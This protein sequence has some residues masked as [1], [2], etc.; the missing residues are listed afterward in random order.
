[1]AE[2]PPFV[3]HRDDVPEVE[4]RYPAPFNAEALSLGRDLGRTAGSRALGTWVERLLPGRRT[5]FTHAHLREEEHV[6]VLDGHPTLRWLPPDGEGG[7]VEL[8]PGHFV[9]FPAGTGIAHTFVNHGDQDALLLVVGERR[10][11]ERAAYP[12]DGAYEAWRRKRRPHTVWSDRAGPVGEA[13]PPAY[14][15]ET[16]RLVLR[17]WEPA[18]AAPLRDLVERNHE[19]LKPWMPWAQTI[20]TLDEEIALV[21]GFRAR[22]DRDEDYVLGVFLPDGRPIGGTGYHPRVG[23]DAL[24]IGYWIDRQHQGQGYVTEWVAALCRVA[25][26]AMGIERLDVHCAPENERSAAVPLRLGFRDEGV[27]RARE[28]GV[29]GRLRDTRVFTLLARELG[30]SPAA[31]ARVR[32]WDAAGRRLL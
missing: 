15:I 4:V 12:E 22:Y 17:P 27:L 9:A 10:A 23:P 2:A 16:D 32:A 13:R 8:R 24:E 30:A 20:P 25:F 3:V 26:D 18:D 21:R 31:A 29:D 5:S 6:Y 1:M 14:R 7:E 11:G 28:I 19:H